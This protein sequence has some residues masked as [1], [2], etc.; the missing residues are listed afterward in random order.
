VPVTLTFGPLPSADAPAAGLTAYITGPTIDLIVVRTGED[1]TA[2]VELPVPD[3]PTE[4]TPYFVSWQRRGHLIRVPSKRVLLRATDG[5][6][7]AYDDLLP[8]RNVPN[9][10][11][12]Y[13]LGPVGPQ[14]PQGPQGPEGPTGPQGPTGPRGPQGDRGPTGDRGA[15]GL[16]GA[17]GPVGPTGA[18]GPRG[19]TGGTGP[20]GAGG[21]AGPAGPRGPTGPVGP[22]GPQGS[23]GPQGATGPIGPIG[24][25]GLT[26]RGTWDPGTAYAT[27]DAV[28]WD[29][30]S[31]F[32][33]APST[34]VTPTTDTGT[35]WQPLAVRG[36]TGATGPQGAQGAQGATGVQGPTGAT[37]A[38]GP[39]GPQ[40]AT[41]AQ[42]PQGTTG[43]TGAKGDPGDLVASDTATAGATFTPGYTSPHTAVR[44]L[45]ANTVANAL[46]TPPGSVS[47]TCTTVLIQATGA[48]PFTASWPIA[49]KWAQGA[50][51][52]V[53]PTTAGT[54]LVVNLFWTGTEW[55]G[56]VAGTF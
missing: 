24:P 10:S 20:Q 7:V 56:M 43:A 45:T 53:M 21:P 55:L 48:G 4:G 38:Q 22:T 12:P 23:T 25:A 27:D 42:G 50:A 30:S 32:A 52:P 44:T 49:A 33:T 6:T 19:S 26:W 11:A 35:D 16:T 40:G 39:V 37:G 46:P 3:D 28:F 34:G 2:A 1:G 41:G 8:S 9:V 54:R 17:P 29:G 31:W 13:D 18:T 47:F 14:G 36:A 51:A 5:P 15:P